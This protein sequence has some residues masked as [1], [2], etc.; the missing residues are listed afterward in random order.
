VNTG[1]QAAVLAG[2]RLDPI[3]ADSARLGWVFNN[4]FSMLLL[5][6]TWLYERLMRRA[7]MVAGARSRRLPYRGGS[8]HV[9]DLKG[10]GKLA[11]VVLL[12]GFSASGASQ[13]GALV[14]HLRSQ[15]SRII[16]P[17]L[18]GHGLSSVPP[19]L[20]D[21]VMVEA[22]EVV[23]DRFIDRPTVVFAASMAGGVAVRFAQAQPE[24]LAGLM[25]CSPGGAPIAPDQLDEFRATFQIGSHRQALQF[26]DRLFPR[27]HPLRQAYAWGV[28]QQFNRPHLVGLL[29]RL[30][31]LQFLRPDE[32][33]SLSM[34]VSL[35]W[36]RRD[37]I[38][39]PSQFEFYR[40]HLPSHAEID[41]PPSFGHAPFLHQA[42]AVA[43]R[44][45][46]FAR[47]VS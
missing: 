14:R 5:S 9:L 15:V 19:K 4:S 44:L 33:R 11:P 13:Y 1:V 25:L 23:A 30:G 27:R 26:V 34:P 8:L 28:R 36:G 46:R 10:S 42:D 31:D 32:L 37:H 18:P 35:L 17:D 29:E 41:T 22:L 45:L 12:H 2:W 20:D 47:R 6:G 39:P 16:L 24:R 40:D 3:A 43:R 38:L 7:F 21:E